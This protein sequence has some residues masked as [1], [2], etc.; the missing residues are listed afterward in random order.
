MFLIAVLIIM[1]YIIDL[2]LIVE[3]QYRSWGELILDFYDDKFNH[4]FTK[5]DR[6]ELILNELLKITTT[7]T[8]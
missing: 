2:K 7:T 4:Q 3:L 5:E 1:L 6:R 8:T